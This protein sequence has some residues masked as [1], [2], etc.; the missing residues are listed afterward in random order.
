M[1]I[2]LLPILLASLGLCASSPVAQEV[3]RP[4]LSIPAPRWDAPWYVRMDGSRV[5]LAQGNELGGR[6]RVEEEE[7]R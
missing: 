6:E 1:R 7:K 4:F 2:P 3:V 5:A